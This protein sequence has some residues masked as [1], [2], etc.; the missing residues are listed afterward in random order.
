MDHLNSSHRVIFILRLWIDNSNPAC[1]YGRIE[2]VDTRE[3]VMIN[4]SDD[5]VNYLNGIVRE[6]NKTK[7]NTSQLK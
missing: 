1:W 6:I 4:N 3:I 7:L 2:Q 5:L